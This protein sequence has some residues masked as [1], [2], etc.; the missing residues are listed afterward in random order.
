M[1]G[2]RSDYGETGGSEANLSKEETWR[3]L[4]RKARVD[5]QS[6]TEDEVQE[7]KDKVLKFWFL[8]DFYLLEAIQKGDVRWVDIAMA[9]IEYLNKVVDQ[10]LVRKCL[11]GDEEALCQTHRF[12]MNEEW[13]ERANN[14]DLS[15][16]IWRRDKNG[17]LKWKN[18]REN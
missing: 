12:L 18:K 6:I 14:L 15:K 9:R 5:R 8:L 1:A 16:T 2:R 17:R 4:V 10:E 11:E 7:L 3:N 13:W